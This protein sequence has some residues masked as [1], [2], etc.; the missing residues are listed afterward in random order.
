MSEMDAFEMDVFETRFEQRLQRYAHI[1]VRPVDAAAV[2]A[3]AV[4]STGGV[5]RR[6]G[7]GWSPMLRPGFGSAALLVILGL[8]LAIAL[9]F[10][11]ASLNNLP[12][13]PVLG[14]NGIIAFEVGP[15]GIRTGSFHT[16]N[17]DGTGEQDFG[18]AMSPRFSTDGRSLVYFRGF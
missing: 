10:V 4:A 14:Q 2:T 11:A 8:L 16:I 13:N 6:L 9:A 1:P 18:S 15:I 7:I 12:R 5:W 17:A 3:A